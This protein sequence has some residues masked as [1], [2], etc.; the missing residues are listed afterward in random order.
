M[1]VTR[2]N[3]HSQPQ[4]SVCVYVFRPNAEDATRRHRRVLCFMLVGMARQAIISTQAESPSSETR[5]YNSRAQTSWCVRRFY[6]STFMTVPCTTWGAWPIARGGPNTVIV[7]AH[8]CVC[9]YVPATFANQQRTLCTHTR[10]RGAKRIYMLQ[11]ALCRS[12]WT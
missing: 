6:I 3:T 4:C 10:R 5:L 12:Q 8:V 9:V 7:I 1:Q 2:L 11:T